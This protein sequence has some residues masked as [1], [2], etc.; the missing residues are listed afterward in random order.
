LRLEKT[1]VHS[2]VKETQQSYIRP[3]LSS[4]TLL[5]SHA[6][7]FIFYSLSCLYFPRKWDRWEGKG[8]ML[9]QA[10]RATAGNIA[11]SPL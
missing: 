8:S 4:S 5:P 3:F 2:K 1:L 7:F 11:F 10:L 9:F 6:S